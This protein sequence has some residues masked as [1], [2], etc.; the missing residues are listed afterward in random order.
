MARRD[1]YMVL[2]I[3]RHE[4]PGGIRTAFRALVKRYHPDY[5]GPGWVERFQEIMEAYQVLS[6]PE[7]RK[8]YDRRLFQAEA[9]PA[10]HSMPVFPAGGKEPEALVPQR[11]SVMR[12]FFTGN[13]SFDALFAR[14]FRNFSGMGIPKAERPES[15]GVELILTADEAVRGGQVAIG[16][17]V[18]FPCPFCGGSG[19]QWP[20][21]C[22]ECG[23][24]GLLEEEESVQV[25]IPH[26][27]RSGDVFEIP[28]RGVG[29]HNFY[30]RVVIRV[31]AQ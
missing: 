4:S 17:P 30:L 23:G 31:G 12:D 6:D 11:V 22:S 29:I 10:R 26:R 19:S 7:Q 1:Y 21:R 25:V 28:L 20:F 24:R 2:G 8:Y 27:V 13:E 18:F 16:V 5:V 15:L 9:F 14:F 3:S